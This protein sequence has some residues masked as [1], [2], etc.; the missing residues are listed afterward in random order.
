MRLKSQLEHYHRLIEKK[1]EAGTNVSTSVRKS[2]AAPLSHKSTT[3]S[4][5][6]SKKQQNTRRGITT[7]E[8]NIA[9]S[10]APKVT[11]ETADADTT[12]KVASPSVPVATEG[13]GVPISAVREDAVTS[14]SASDT[15]KSLLHS[16]ETSG[17]FSNKENIGSIRGLNGSR[18]NSMDEMLKGILDS[19]DEEIGQ[20]AEL[21]DINEA[22]LLASDE[23]SDTTVGT[24]AAD[25]VEEG[26]D[27]GTESMEVDVLPEKP[28]VVDAAKER[29]ELYLREKLLKA[30]LLKKMEASNERLKLRKLERNIV[31]SR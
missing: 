7:T 28:F 6:L 4:S 3:S 14:Q 5:G 16:N 26:K 10:S 23:E 11:L 27:S 13:P 22:K 24:T 25:L 8:M 9:S 12:H 18:R 21:L 20:D 30:Q 17:S 31:S 29:E 15:H 19:A 2:G 1:K